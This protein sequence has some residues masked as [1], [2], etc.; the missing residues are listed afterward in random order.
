[1]QHVFFFY[2]TAGS[3]HQAAANRATSTLILHAAVNDIKDIGQLH[4][5]V[6]SFELSMVESVRKQVDLLEIKRLKIEEGQ[7]CQAINYAENPKK[8]KRCYAAPH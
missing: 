7:C 4:P 3:D 1:M 8:R 6:K 5:E 2:G